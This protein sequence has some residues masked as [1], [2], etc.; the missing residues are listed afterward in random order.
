[1][2]AQG[3]SATEIQQALD[4]QMESDENPLAQA[5][6]AL[7]KVDSNE[8]LAQVLEQHPLLLQA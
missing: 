8:A 5:I 1:M 4:A 3:L 6:S 7:L 2:Q